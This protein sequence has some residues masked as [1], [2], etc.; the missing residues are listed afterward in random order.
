[1]FIVVCVLFVVGW[2]RRVECVCFPCTRTHT[3]LKEKKKKKLH[4]LYEVCR[5]NEEDRNKYNLGKFDSRTNK[6]I[7][8]DYASRSKAYKCYNKIMHKVVDSIDV[9]VDESIPQE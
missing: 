5:R 9:R 3:L 1:V 7:F 8:L 2:R 6:G 4:L